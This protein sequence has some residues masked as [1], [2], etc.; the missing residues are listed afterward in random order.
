MQ[1]TDAYYQQY[2]IESNTRPGPVCLLM[3][4]G[5]FYE[6]YSRSDHTGSNAAQ[7]ARDLGMGLRP[8][9]SQTLM[10]GFPVSAFDLKKET[11]LDRGY[12]IVLLDETADADGT[13]MKRNVTRAI[14]RIQPEDV[15]ETVTLDA[16]FL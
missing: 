4:V 8:K 15:G 3:Q 9:D 13:G 12:S 5:Y 2:A 1:L 10:A 7:I 14:T 16:H 6:L 11:L